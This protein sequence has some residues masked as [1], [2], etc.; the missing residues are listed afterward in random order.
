MDQLLT[1]PEAAERLRRSRW[2]IYDLVADGVLERHYSGRPGK[3]PSLRISERDLQAYI[4]SIKAAPIP[5]Q[6]GSAEPVE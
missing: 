5:K 2:H 3:K 1:V 6:R 4:N